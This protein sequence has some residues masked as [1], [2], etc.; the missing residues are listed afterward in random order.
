MQ[1]ITNWT[2]RRLECLQDLP[3]SKQSDFGYVDD[4]CSLRFV[5]YRGEW[6]D[7]FDAQRIEP[8]TGRT[9]PMG[10]AMRV[11]AGSP[12]CLFDSIESDSYFS[13]LLYRFGGDE[14]VIVARYFS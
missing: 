11:H 5:C 12:L 1:I 6:H 3:E 13:G 8:N 10:W 4:D 9:S 2:P 14:T 7:V